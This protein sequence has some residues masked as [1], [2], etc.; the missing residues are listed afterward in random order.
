MEYKIKPPGKPTCLECGNVIT[1]G[2]LDKKFCCDSCKN[3]YHNR[4]QKDSRDIHRKVLR[5]LEKNYEIL[6]K[7]HRTSITSIGIGDLLSMGFR[8]EY[9][10]SYRKV[11]SHDEFRCFEF[12]YYI[13]QTRL[14]NLQKVPTAI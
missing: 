11:N 3:K 9:S 6:K 12:K 2:R 4:E 8:P 5:G 7:L 14:F 13:S 1:Y 10:T